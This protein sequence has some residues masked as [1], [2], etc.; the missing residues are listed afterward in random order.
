[1]SLG[2]DVLDVLHQ[3]KHSA[4]FRARYKNEIVIV[5]THPLPYGTPSE[6]ES[7]EREYKIGRLVMSNSAHVP[8]Y[9][10]IV[11]HQHDAKRKAVAIVMADSKG[12]PLS[13]LI[14]AKGF[15]LDTFLDIAIESVKGLRDIHR[16]NIIHKDVKPANMVW[17]TFEF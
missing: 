14:P 13:S 10:Q 5:K 1:M 8:R 15:P 12:Q 16:H 7:L 17:C 3:G 11:S 9:L 6:V 2:F 4:V